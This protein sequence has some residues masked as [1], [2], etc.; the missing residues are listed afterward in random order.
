MKVGTFAPLGPGL[1]ID[2]ETRRAHLAWGEARYCAGGEEAEAFW[3]RVY[4]E[5]CRRG[6]GTPR[7]RT[8]VLLGDGAEWIWHRARH[9]LRVRGVELVEIV[10][11][12]HAYEYLWTVGNAVFG[13]GSARAAGWVQ[14]LKDRLYEQGAAPI[15]AALAALTP[16]TDAAAEPSASPSATSPRTPRAWT[17]PSSWRGSSPSARARWKAPARCSSRPAR[18][19]RG[20]AGAG[21]ASK[22]WPACAR[23]SARAA[24]IASGGHSLSG[25]LPTCT[26]SPVR[27]RPRSYRCPSHVT[28]RRLHWSPQRPPLRQRIRCPV[29]ARRRYVTSAPSSP[30]APAPR[31]ITFLG[32]TRIALPGL[33]NRVECCIF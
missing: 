28:P 14:P 4:A 25:A 6:L 5:A 23:C 13:A 8:V 24:G 26:P 2:A 3:W 15:L 32:Y 27:A 16:D 18:R 30:H 10:D 19:G 21:P 1:R 31:E 29:R 9:F 22:R 17:T 20:C 33:S 12:Y 11:I 7:V